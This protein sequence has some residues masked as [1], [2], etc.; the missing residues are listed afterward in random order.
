MKLRKWHIFFNAQN[1]V[2]RV[3]IA[4]ALADCTLFATD[5]ARALQLTQRNAQIDDELFAALERWEVLGDKAIY[6]CSHTG[7]SK[8]SL[9][10]NEAM[11]VTAS[12]LWRAGKRLS[13]VGMT[14]SHGAVIDAEQI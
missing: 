7:L 10:R 2:I 14:D 11:C 5:S 3:S 1:V 13:G 4:S 9:A 6:H 12:Y 8:P